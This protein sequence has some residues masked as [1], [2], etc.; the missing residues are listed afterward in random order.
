MKNVSIIFDNHSHNKK[1]VCDIA[2]RLIANDYLVFDHIRM[3]IDR[4]NID[5][6][7][8]NIKNRVRLVLDDVHTPSRK[9]STYEETAKKAKHILDKYGKRI[10]PA[11]SCRLQRIIELS[12]DEFDN[13]LRERDGCIA[14]LEPL[15]KELEEIDGPADLLNELEDLIKNHSKAE[16]K[17]L[18]CYRHSKIGSK[19][20]SE[21]VIYLRNCLGNTS[22]ISYNYETILSTFAHEVFHAY[23]YH[24]YDSVFLNKQSIDNGDFTTEIVLESLASYFEESFDEYN[25]LHERADEIKESWYRHAMRAFPYAGARF[26]GQDNYRFRQ[27]FDATLIDFAS[28]FLSLTPFAY[29]KLTKLP[30]KQVVLFKL[31][32]AFLRGRVDRNFIDHYQ[33]NNGDF[34]MVSPLLVNYWNMSKR[35]EGTCYPDVLVALNEEIFYVYKDWDEEGILKLIRFQF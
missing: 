28:T 7:F 22:D 35:M 15:L 5:S 18:G 14:E 32:E 24:E 8:Q 17:T 30:Y 29:R 10:L 21:I 27:L 23:H 20:E 31:T 19:K 12:N 1:E 16:Y 13:H 3:L 4:P 11:I 33:S 25:Q 9:G 34:H 6:V 26:I 2:D